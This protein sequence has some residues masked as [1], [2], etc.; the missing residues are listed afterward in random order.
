MNRESATL[1]GGLLAGVG[2]TLC[3]TAPLVLLSLGLTGAWMGYLTGL[4][5]YSWLFLLAAAASLGYAYYRIFIRP[6][7]I[8][9]DADDWCARPTVRR[10]YRIAFWLVTVLVALAAA[11]PYLIALFY[12]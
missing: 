1:A 10:G 9:C 11:S 5:P 8:A 4:E 12:T 3:C 2:A 6:K 7:R